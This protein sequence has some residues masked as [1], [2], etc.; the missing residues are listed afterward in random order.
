MFGAAE[1]SPRFRRRRRRRFRSARHRRRRRRRRERDAGAIAVPDSDDL[2][3]DGD[4]DDV[5]EQ[6]ESTDGPGSCQVAPVA[7]I[8]LGVIAIGLIRRRQ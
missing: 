4:P 8:W 6:F 3:D 7:W 5:D 1:L 2:V